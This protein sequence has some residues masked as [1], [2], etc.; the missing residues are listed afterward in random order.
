MTEAPGAP[1]GTPRWT[2]SAKSGVGTALSAVSRVWFTI[3]HGILNE[4]YF[5]RVDQACIRDLG[6]IVTDGRGF[7]AEEKRDCTFEV[8]SIADGVPA[9]RLVN[10]HRG[11]RFR[12]VKRIITDP[13]SDVVLQQIAL[14]DLTGEGLRLFALLSPHMVNCGAHNRAWTG[15]YKGHGMLFAEGRGTYLAMAADR[16]FLAA[17]VGFVGASDG[18]RLLS[19]DGHLAEQ[20]DT[21]M[22]GNVALTAELPVSAHHPVVL[23]LGF[24]SS[25]A[26]AGFHAHS[27]LLT[28]FETVLNDYAA[29]WRT[30]QAGLRPLER[31]A[32]GHNMYRVSTAVLR[33]HESP[34]FPGGLIASLSIPWG[35]S[36]GDDDLGGYHLVWPRDLAE[37]AGALLACGAETRSAP[38]LAL[39]ARHAGRGRI[40]A[41]ELLARWRTILA[42]AAARR[43][44]LSH[45]AAGH[46]LALRCAAAAGVAGILA[47]AAA[48]GR[49][50]AV[51][52]SAH[53]PGPVGGKRRVHA[54]HAGGRHRV[55]AGRGGDCRGVRDRRPVRPVARYG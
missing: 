13:R 33:S 14:E 50:R 10:T 2:S 51:P 41:T 44:R 43:V 6:L 12:I 4:V 35:F 20:Y 25:E 29:S 19:R 1:G 16:P 3:S 30:W 46:G 23:A 26:A 36:K 17:S 8:E 39:P 11:G 34:N 49:F 28:P 9:F 47:D 54:V 7:F 53:A 15:A 32:R 42:G 37:T 55:P 52:W 21:A 31:K 24:G 48:R 38:H 18:W 45:A 22:D 40:L 5:P 27:S